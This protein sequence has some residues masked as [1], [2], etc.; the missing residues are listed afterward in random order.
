MQNAPRKAGRWG[1]V[2]FREEQSNTEG[3]L[4]RLLFSHHFGTELQRQ[5]ARLTKRLPI[6]DFDELKIHIQ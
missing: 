2:F 1:S 4:S 3:T 6:R 5:R